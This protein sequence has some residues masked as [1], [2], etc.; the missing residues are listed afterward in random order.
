M[1]ANPKPAR[2]VAAPPVVARDAV[3]VAGLCTAKEIR[4]ERISAVV[5]FAEALQLAIRDSQGLYLRKQ[6]AANGRG[7]RA[8]RG[9]R[10]DRAAG[11]S[12][13][14]HNRGHRNKNAGNPETSRTSHLASS[15]DQGV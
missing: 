13:R 10:G 4:T 2:H 11:D 9:R 1:N 6:L 12:N 8:R 15:L 5:R 3:R 14:G 7:A